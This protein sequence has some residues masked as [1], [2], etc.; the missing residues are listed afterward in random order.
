MSKSPPNE[1]EKKR[2]RYEY[3]VWGE[4]PKA[5][6]LL[7]SIATDSSREQIEDCYFL[8]E[9]P[10]WNAKVRD[11]TLKVKQLVNES[12]GFEQWVSRWHTDGDS[13]PAPFDDLFDELGLDRPARGKSFSLERAVKDLDPEIAATAMFVTKD[14][15]RYRVGDLKAEVTDVTVH[16][17][18]EVLCTIAIEGNNLDNLVALRKKLG[19]KGEDNVAVHVAIDPEG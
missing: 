3:R 1:N 4:Y 2:T 5:R 15:K 12:K 11:S 19:L 14:R 10:S 9:D 17:T 8:T 16:E 7:A 6:K 13:A 18:G